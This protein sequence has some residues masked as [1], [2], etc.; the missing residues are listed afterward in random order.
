MTQ[1]NDRVARSTEHAPAIARRSTL[2]TRSPLRSLGVMG[3][4]GALVA[5]VALPAYTGSAP[6]NATTLQQIATDNAQS[7]VVA[8]EIAPLALER[9]IYLAT[10]QKEIDTLRVQR[11][12][13]ARFGQAAFVSSMLAKSQYPLTSPGSGEV[14]Y[15][16]PKGSYTISRTVIPGVHRGADMAA[17]SGTP[18]YAATSGTVRI[19]SESLYGWGVAVIIDGVVS[20]Q[21][22][23][24]IYGHMT[25]GSRQVQTGATV[26]AG[27]LIGLVGNTGRSNGSHLHIEVRVGGA[28]VE[29]IEWLRI[30]AD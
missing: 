23:S 27:Q 1:D 17:R 28:L 24:T 11:S 25:H 12:A 29:P 22:V 20:G 18:I 4:V 26:K 5:A 6:A 30:N 7:L 16:L 9:G 10:T 3:A 21:S 8:S 19:S 14:R 2:T 13:A 15:P